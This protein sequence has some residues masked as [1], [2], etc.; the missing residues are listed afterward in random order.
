MPWQYEPYSRLDAGKKQQIIQEYRQKFLD[1]DNDIIVNSAVEVLQANGYNNFHSLQVGPE[2]HGQNFELWLQLTG[3]I[4]NDKRYTIFSLPTHGGRHSVGVVIDTQAKECHVLDSQG[5]TY[6]EAEQQLNEAIDFGGLANY[7]IIKPRSNKVQQSDSWSCG[8]HT[9]AN[10]VGIV[11]GDINLK[12]GKGIQ[13]RSAEEIDDLLGTFSKAYAEIS[14]KRGAALDEPRLYA[15]QKKALRLALEALITSDEKIIAD[16]N[17]L[18]TAL[19]IECPPGLDEEELLKQRQ[20]AIFF[21]EFNRA[22]PDN[23]FIPLI[24]KD[25]FARL[26]PATMQDDVGQKEQEI[27]AFFT[28]QLKPKKELTQTQ[29]KLP[30]DDYRGEPAELPAVDV[31]KVIDDEEDLELILS[32]ANLT[33]QGL[34]NPKKS[35]SNITIQQD[36]DLSSD[37]LVKQAQLQSVRDLIRKLDKEINSCWPYPNKDRKQVKL[38]ALN[39]LLMLAKTHSVSESANL[40]I[41]KY[42][43]KGLLEGKISTRTSDLL[44]ELQATQPQKKHKG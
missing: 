37:D 11:T 18:V 24:Q 7:N 44:T 27:T 26:L 32:T 14:V 2:R 6:A 36:P 41:N 33:E 38:D 31:K 21:D 30:E 35:A 3:K 17:Q 39:E 1:F 43:D 4:P 10:L 5:I 34:F 8:I 16:K 15:R 28:E 23:L 22:N 20:F 40:V 25:D 29:Q 12:T 13:P 42:G 9:A 19:R